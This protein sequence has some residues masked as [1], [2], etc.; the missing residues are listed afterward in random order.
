[1]KSGKSNKNCINKINSQ[2]SFSFIFLAFSFQVL[3]LC[4][5]RTNQIVS[6]I[7]TVIILTFTINKKRVYIFKGTSSQN[8]VLETS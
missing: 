5:H 7:V 4:P 6:N 3:S 1:M 8:G 2:Y